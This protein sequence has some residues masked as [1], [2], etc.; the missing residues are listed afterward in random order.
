[1]LRIV[2]S[3]IE[4]RGLPARWGSAARPMLAALVRQGRADRACLAYDLITTRSR[5]SDTPATDEPGKRSQLAAY[6]WATAS[7]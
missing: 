1:M 4:A 7:S 2:T 5:G 3:S 6:P